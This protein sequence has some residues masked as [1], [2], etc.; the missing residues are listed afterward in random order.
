MVIRKTMSSLE[1]YF[2]V[3]KPMC[4]KQKVPHK[5][6]VHVVPKKTTFDDLPR[7][8]Q[9][10]IWKE[11]YHNAHK[12]VGRVFYII[13]DIEAEFIDF[14]Y[15]HGIRDIR[16]NC[17][18]KCGTKIVN[19]EIPDLDDCFQEFYDKL[20]INLLTVFND[21]MKATLI[22]TSINFEIE[23][24]FFGVVSRKQVELKFERVI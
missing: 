19:I 18:I 16:K 21:L 1:T 6:L 8:I 12:H 24:V 9:M 15:K 4:L 11:Y 20:K 17:H 7:H 10:M 3:A 14:V 23:D 13:Q 2:M 5:N 22:K